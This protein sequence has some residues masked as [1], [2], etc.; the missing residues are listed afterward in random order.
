MGTK[1]NFTKLAGNP[2]PVV[3]MPHQKLPNRMTGLYLLALRSHLAQR[4]P[5]LAARKQVIAVETDKME[6]RPELVEITRS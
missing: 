2:P 5:A 3:E 4:P 6:S 1:I